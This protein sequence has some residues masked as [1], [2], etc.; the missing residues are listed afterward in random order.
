MLLNRTSG[1][2]AGGEMSWNE[3]MAAYLNGEEP[4]SWADRY[5][6]NVV[7]QGH[8]SP[9]GKRL[10][11]PPKLPKLPSYKDALTFKNLASAVFTP[12]VSKLITGELL[13]ETKEKYNNLKNNIQS[14]I[15]Y[16]RSN[17]YD[18]LINEAANRELSK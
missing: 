4:P 6:G 5:A 13:K 15:Q 16:K 17:I 11:T 12:Y 10:P 18:A 1:S 8:M 2:A 9:D 14:E 3:A 7:P